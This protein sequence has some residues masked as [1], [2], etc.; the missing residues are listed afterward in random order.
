MTYTMTHSFPSLLIPSPPLVPCRAPPPLPHVNPFSYLARRAPLPC[1]CPALP[2]FWPWHQVHDGGGND[3]DL[4]RYVVQL[5]AVVCVCVLAAM[6]M[7][8][9]EDGLFALGFSHLVCMYVCLRVTQ[10]RGL[11]GSMCG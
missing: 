2:I 7:C 10:W 8:A 5:C 4:C 6:R 9:S 3:D 1:P 11:L